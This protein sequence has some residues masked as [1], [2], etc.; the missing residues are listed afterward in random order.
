VP[1]EW[2]AFA[3]V[4]GGRG[5]VGKDERPV[6]EGQAAIFATDGESVTLAAADARVPLE[7]LLVAGLPLREPVA[8]YGPFV[9]NTREEIVQAV[10]DFRVGR[11][12][13]RG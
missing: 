7:A 4:F 1:R 3:Y 5:R 8:R 11:L 2:N 10:E 12:G 9:M 6:N 13:R